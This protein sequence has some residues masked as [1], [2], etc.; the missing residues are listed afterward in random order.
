VHLIPTFGRQVDL[1]KFKEDQPG[2]H[3]ESPPPKQQQ[4]KEQEE[5]SLH[6]ALPQA[7][8]LR[9]SLEQLLGKTAYNHLQERSAGPNVSVSFPSLLELRVFYRYSF[10]FIIS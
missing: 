10:G 5:N 6:S 9:G 3:S 8:Y 4:N 7:A 2:L 1:S